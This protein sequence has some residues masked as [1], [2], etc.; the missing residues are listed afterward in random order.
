MLLDRWR[1]AAERRSLTACESDRFQD[2]FAPSMGSTALIPAAPPG[3][4]AA[5]AAG[6]VERRPH[7][8][9]PA[10]VYLARLSPSSRHTMRGALDV[11][12][13]VASGGEADAE[14]F[15]W[16]LLGYAHTAALRAVL[17]ERYAPATANRHLAAL[18]GVLQE[19]WRLGHMSAED[20][21]RAADL[22]GVPG[23]T[24]P[25]GREITDGELYALFRACAEDPTAAG[26]RDAAILVLLYGAL[27]RRGEAARLRVGDVLLETGRIRVRRGKGAKDRYTYVEGGAREM[28]G[29]WLEVRGG[30]AGPLL[31]SVSQTGVVTLRAMTDQ[32][33]YLRIA[34]RARQA[35]VRE[36]S[37]HDFRRTGI[38]NL[39]DAGADISAVQQLAGHSN[40]TT[41]QRYDR[42]GERAKR[43]AAGML[44]VPH[45]RRSRP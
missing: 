13:A 25:A 22:R 16:Q 21:H 1:K 44:H 5:D 29:E 32:A 12:A 19:A 20:Y 45:I 23:S 10:L 43:K 41:T 28:L 39:L 42:R 30:E 9:K 7:D 27:L 4:L 8:R 6:A 36:I 2:R 33:L 34:R 17:A 40:V 14:A 38:G 26:Y 35:G 18:R 11:I 24:L 3:W 31:V 15:P 37:P